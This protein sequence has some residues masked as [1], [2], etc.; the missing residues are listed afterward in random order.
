M[1]IH[2]HLSHFSYCFAVSLVKEAVGGG[3]QKMV[4]NLALSPISKPKLLYL[5]RMFQRKTAI[6]T[7]CQTIMYPGGA[8]K[9]LLC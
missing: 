5:T 9:G 1:F 6:C 2:L 8:G 7:R 3:E 4:S